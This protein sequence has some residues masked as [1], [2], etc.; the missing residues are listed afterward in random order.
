V[1]EKRVSLGSA[2]SWARTIATIIIIVG[3]VVYLYGLYVASKD[4]RVELAGVPEVGLAGYR[5]VS[6]E[7]PVR[8]YNPDGE[9]LA[10]LVYY[11]VYIEGEYAGDGFIPYLSLPSGWSEH[12]V[13]AEI[14]LARAGCGVSRALAEGGTISVRL[15]GYAMVDIKTI[16]GLTWKTVTVPF[17]VSAAEVEA[18]ALDDKTRAFIR[19]FLLIC[20]APEQLSTVLG[21]L[22]GF[23][24]GLPETSPSPEAGP[25]VVE[26]EYADAGLARKE[27]VVVVSN[28][29]GEPVTVERVVVNGEAVEVGMVVEPGGEIRVETGVVLPVGAPV[30]VVV[31]T[32]AGVFEASGTVGLGG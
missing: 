23:D 5:S 14:D 4:W 8:I 28:S 32:S 16:G 2:V 18:P 17:N 9:V 13:R 31:E 10:K 25:I 12:V 3:A 27:V 20:D 1:G 6:V 22:D 21:G 11:R 19:V 7:V 29:G 30:S 24:L 26:L 15:E